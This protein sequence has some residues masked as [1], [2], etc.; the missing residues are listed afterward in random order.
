MRYFIFLCLMLPLFSIGQNVTYHGK[1]IQQLLSDSGTIIKNQRQG[2]WIL[3]S[4]DTLSRRKMPDSISINGKKFKAF[5]DTV[6]LKEQGFFRDDKREGLW[7]KSYS[8]TPEINK[9]WILTNRTMYVNGL[10]NGDDTLFQKTSSNGFV[11]LQ[12]THYVNDK[13]MPVFS[14][15]YDKAPYSLKAEYKPFDD[16]V[17]ALREFYEDGKPKVRVVD[18]VLNGLKSY[19]MYQYFHG[20]RVNVCGAFDSL[21]RSQGGWKNFY[22][23]GAIEFI[24]NYKDNQFDGSYQYFYE[25]GQLWTHRVYKN[26]LLTEIISNF[27]SSGKALD[28]GTIKNGNGSVNIYDENG[29]LIQTQKFKNGEEIE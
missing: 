22:E 15:Y 14:M 29:H 20:G 10:K 3:Y 26:G 23:S 5:K 21:Y 28:K 6:I 24:V 12:I 9:S 8:Y 1:P 25:N 13:R 18:T 11:P 16:K 7:S 27:T 17:I 4:I 19:F 2:N